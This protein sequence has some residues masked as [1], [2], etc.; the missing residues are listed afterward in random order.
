PMETS[1][2]GSPGID[3]TSGR[4]PDRAPLGS[5]VTTCRTSGSSARWLSIWTAISTSP[6]KTDAWESRSMYVFSGVASGRL[7]PTQMAPRRMAPRNAM[8]M[9]T[10]FGSAAATRSPCST[11]SDRRALAAR[12][13]APSSSLTV[14]RPWRPTSAR[15]SGACES[16]SSSSVAIVPGPPGSLGRDCG[17]RPCASRSIN[18]V[19]RTI[20]M[21]DAQS[22]FAIEDPA[23]LAAP[24]VMYKGLRD[25]TPVLSIDGPPAVAIVTT[26]EAIRHVLRHP[27][28]FSSGVDAVAIGQIRP[29]IPLQIDPPEHSKYRKLLDP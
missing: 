17:A 23:L 21:S 2:I 6:R 24:Q 25:T 4:H 13:T 19:D 7:R 15:R 22:L 14:K 12:R 29:L 18:G 8:T 1:S 27:E 11:P 10:S 20:P 3:A 28:V 16:A 26:D 5:T 9:S